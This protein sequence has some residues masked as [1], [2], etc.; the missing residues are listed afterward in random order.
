MNDEAQ[1]P[2][3]A[4]QDREQGTK[5]MDEEPDGRTVET[6]TDEPSADDGDPGED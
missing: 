4:G 3:E 2:D 6:S 1:Q 5:H